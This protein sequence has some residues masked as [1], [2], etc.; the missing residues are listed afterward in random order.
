MAYLWRSL[1][2]AWPATKHCARKARTDSVPL[3]VTSE[4]WRRF[5]AVLV[6]VV[7][8]SHATLGQ[9]QMELFQRA[10]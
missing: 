3:Y 5:G 6:H 2:E 1:E 4:G 8:W 7:I 9:W 10:N